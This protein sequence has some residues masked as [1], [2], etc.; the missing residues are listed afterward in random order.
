VNLD[1]A[2]VEKIKA[3][4]LDA[5]LCR[6][7]ELPLLGI[8]G[9]LFVS[10][11]ML[12]HLHNPALFLRRLAKQTECRLLVVTVPFR[13]NSRVG[14]HTIRNDIREAVTAEGEHIFELNPSDWKL[15]MLHS[16]WRIVQ[17]E[18]YYQYPTAWPVANTLLSW[19][20]RTKD[21]EGFWG[22][23]LQKDVSVCD[24]YLDWEDKA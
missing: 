24:R 14:L 22:A 12:E 6:A 17:E 4:G 20:W 5:V 8:T 2:A 19:Y 15:L 18:T 11:E 3:R 13:R 10:F 7:E 21:F 9:D 1:P 16:G 23:I